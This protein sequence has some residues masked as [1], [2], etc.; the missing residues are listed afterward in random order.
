MHEEFSFFRHQVDH[1]ISRKHGGLSGED[2]LAYACLRCNTWK[3]TDISSVD[4]RSGNLVRLYHPRLDNWD[5]HFLIRG[6]VIEPLT[7]EGTV[8]AR[9]LKLNL[10]K[11]VAERGL[12]IAAGRYP[13]RASALSCLQAL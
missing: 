5:A 4:L 9:L 10:N 6:S 8:T 13:A 2:N 3:G 11:R 7:E 12:L 1:I